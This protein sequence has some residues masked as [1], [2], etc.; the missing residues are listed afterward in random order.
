MP[1]EA[2]DPRWPRVQSLPASAKPHI[3]RQAF[4]EELASFQTF[5]SLFGEAFKTGRAR[6]AVGSESDRLQNCAVRRYICC[7]S[8]I[9][10]GAFVSSDG[11]WFGPHEASC[12]I[13][14]F[15]YIIL[16]RFL[17]GVCNLAAAVFAPSRRLVKRRKHCFER[18]SNT[19]SQEHRD[20]LQTS[21]DQRSQCPSDCCF[22]L[23][24]P[25]VPTPQQRQC[26]AR[27]G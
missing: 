14:G 27:E 6:A 3:V 11:T 18:T 1:S 5:G 16:L 20:Q 7:H 26:K 10:A 25:R 13:I 12:L 2:L 21:R 8:R 23:H 22:S 15:V 4:Q 24:G 17:V 9:L 19:P